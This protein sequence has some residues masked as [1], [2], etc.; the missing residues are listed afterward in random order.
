MIE[1]TLLL[2]NQNLKNQNKFLL[3]Q[4]QKQFR[5]ERAMKKA[6]VGLEG[7]VGWLQ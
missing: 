1:S 7:R 3:E 6:M 2:E 4:I 5:K